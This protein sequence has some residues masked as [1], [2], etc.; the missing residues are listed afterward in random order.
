[1]FKSSIRYLTKQY[2]TKINAQMNHYQNP[3]HKLFALEGCCLCFKFQCSLVHGW[4]NGCT[5]MVAI[6]LSDCVTAQQGWWQERGRRLREQGGHFRGNRGHI[7]HQDRTQ[8]R[9]LNWPLLGEQLQCAPRSVNF[10]SL[11]IVSK[12]GQGPALSKSIWAADWL[13]KEG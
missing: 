6:H 7:C 13:K 12:L 11:S 5:N 8:P 2:L 4:W 10:G 3:K 9:I 1:M